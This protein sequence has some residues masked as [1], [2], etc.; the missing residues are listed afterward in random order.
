MHDRSLRF[1]RSFTSRSLFPEDATNKPVFVTLHFVKGNCVAVNGKKLSPLGVM[2]ALN[3]FGGKH[4]VGRVDMVENRYVGMKSRGVYETPGGAIL[5]FA[6]RQMETLTMDRE[7][8][9]LRDS[10]IPRYA[11]LVYYGYWFAPERHALQA[12]V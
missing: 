10:L 11:E 3:K 7:V 9:H 2:Q 6:H 4:G 12:F 1:R 5:H 8:M